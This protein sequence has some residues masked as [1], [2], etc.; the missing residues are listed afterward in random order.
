MKFLSSIFVFLLLSTS[1]IFAQ[2]LSAVVEEVSN[3]GVLVMLQEISGEVPTT[4]NG[5][6]TTIEHRV[7][8]LGNNNAAAYLKEKLESY[9]LSTEQIDYSSGGRNIVATQLGLENPDKIYMICGHYDSTHK[10]GA[11]DN[12]SGTI[13]VV[14]TARIL[15]Q[16]QFKNTIIYALWDE[17]EIGLVGSRNY[18]QSAKTNGMDIQAVLNMDMVAYDSN[19]DRQYDIDVRNVVNSYQMR[20]DLIAIV[21]ELNLNL[22]E[23]VVDPGTSASDHS[24]FWDQ[25]Y[26][27][28]LLGEAWSV[29]D[30]TPGYHSDND[31]ISLLNLDY[32]YE[33]IRLCV[34]Y[35]TKRADLITT[36]VP[37]LVDKSSIQ[38][39]PNPSTG[40]FNVDFG[41]EIAAE[42]TVIDN[43]GKSVLRTTVKGQKIDIDLS[44]FPGSNYFVRLENNEKAVSI[45]NLIKQ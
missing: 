19:N 12:A 31:R 13:S 1:T 25:G 16:Y 5:T 9:G 17:E 33:M 37:S 26:S 3:E 22:N 29:N 38:I 14:E 23:K 8:A 41:K 21:D 2:S 39:F 4:I 6:E 34:G 35:T 10:H 11:D 40:V 7:S 18:A 44:D 42:L 28:L 36:S 32:Y 24:A 15:S 30:V 27:A 43:N 45:F 20:D